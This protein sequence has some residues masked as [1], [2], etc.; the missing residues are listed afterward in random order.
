MKVREIVENINVKIKSQSRNVR[1]GAL[2]MAAFCI[3]KKM[4]ITAASIRE[5]SDQFYV[6][7]SFLKSSNRF[8]GAGRL[9]TMKNYMPAAVSRQFFLLFP[10]HWP[11]CSCIDRSQYQPV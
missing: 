11:F 8:G 2:T 7:C 9:N 5:Y 1:V 3:G 4:K 6:A 10:S